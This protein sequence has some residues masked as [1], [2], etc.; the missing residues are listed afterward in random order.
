L[1]NPSRKASPILWIPSGPLTASG[2]LSK[3]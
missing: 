2:G 3:A 1:S